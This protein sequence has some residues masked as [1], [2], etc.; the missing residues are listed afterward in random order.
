MKNENIPYKL[1]LNE[2]EMPKA[3]Y[4]L[5]ADMKQK[6]EERFLQSIRELPEASAVQSPKLWK[7]L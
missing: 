3:W 1:Y 5:R 2:S 4:N 7:K 6:L